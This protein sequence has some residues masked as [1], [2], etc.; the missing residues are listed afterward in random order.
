MAV[1]PLLMLATGG[2]AP[3]D[4]PFASAWFNTIKGFAAVAATGLLDALTTW[5]RH[6]HSH[7]LAD[8]LGSFPLSADGES[9]ATLARRVQEQ[10]TA[11]TSADLYLCMAAVALLLILLIPFVATRIYPPRGGLIIENIM[12]YSTI[13]PHLPRAALA[14]ALGLLAYTGWA[15]SGTSPTEST[16]DAA[17]VADHTVVAPQVSG[18]IQEVLAED[19]Q[20]VAA[21]QLLARIDDRE[22]VAALAAARADLAVASAQLVNANATLER[23]QAVI[24]QALAVTRADAADLR[25]AESEVQRHRNL[26]SEGAGTRQAYEQARSRLDMTQARQAEHRHPPGHAQAAGRAGRAAR[27]G[28]GRRAARRRWSTAPNSTCPTPASF[29]RSTA[30]SDAALRVGAYVA[31]ARPSWP[32]C[33]CSRPTWWRTSAKSN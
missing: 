1:I 13:R 33:R 15:W 27:G 10:A 31:P 6:H 16:D 7:M 11:L 4:G 19:N 26:A 18:F 9:A 14:G 22:Y 5:R 8:Q 2:L 23:H 21:G 30:W 17:V 29:R 25:F 20:S 3:Q 32:W 24:S 28:P 12:T